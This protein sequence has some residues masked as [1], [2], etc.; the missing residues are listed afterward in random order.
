MKDARWERG[1]GHRCGRMAR[2]MECHPV[3]V[4]MGQS[5]P[6]NGP[7]RLPGAQY[8]RQFVRAHAPFWNGVCRVPVTDPP[9]CGIGRLPAHRP[10]ALNT[11]REPGIRPSAEEVGPPEPHPIARARA[12]L[13]HAPTRFRRFFFL[14]VSP[15]QSATGRRRWVCIAW[16]WPVCH[17]HRTHPHVEPVAD[18]EQ[19]GVWVCDGQIALCSARPAVHRAF[20]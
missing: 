15:Q 3:Q 9:L 4:A 16:V 12:L 11:L 8:H 18:G 13:Q 7:A 20:S 17:W 14:A 2:C 1:P 5:W 6:S 19:R 10:A